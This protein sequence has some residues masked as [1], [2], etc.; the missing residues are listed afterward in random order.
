MDVHDAQERTEAAERQA[1]VRHELR[2]PLAVI[3]PLLGM[4]LD[5]TA[6]PLGEKQ[7]EYLRMLE[8][9]VGRLAGMITSLVE[10]GWLEIAAL[11]PELAEIPVAGLVQE[12]VADVRASL[13]E[14]PRIEV[15]LE[16]ELPPLRGDPQRLRRALRNVIVNACS[17]TP[18]TGTVTVSAR[19]A[20]REGSILIR[21]D[22]TG[23]GVAPDEASLVFDFGFQGAAGRE[24]EAR[25]LGLGLFVAREIVNAHDG[26]IRLESVPGEGAHMSIELP[27][28]TS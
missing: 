18:P 24:R 21:V 6:G 5:G 4:L 22:D 20:D 17:L 1:F 10:S 3:Q 2:T 23:R 25:G 14:I 11:P 28:S 12:A 13:D 19:R 7:L 8:R 26:L 27:L 15:R 16:D 9:N